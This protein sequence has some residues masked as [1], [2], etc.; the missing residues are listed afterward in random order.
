VKY[1]KEK[2]P[3]THTM[4]MMMKVRLMAWLKKKNVTNASVPK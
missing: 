1:V 2:N 3:T 4:P